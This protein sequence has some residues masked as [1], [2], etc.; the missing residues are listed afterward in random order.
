LDLNREYAME[1]L[2]D[3]DGILVVQAVA[4]GV[5]AAGE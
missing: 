5:F 2:A 3:A 1:K 4:D